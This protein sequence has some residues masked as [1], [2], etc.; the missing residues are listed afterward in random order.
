MKF[1][2]TSLGQKFIMALSGLGLVVFVILHLAGNLSLYGPTGDKFNAY[3]ALLHSFGWLTIAGEIG[4]GALIFTHAILAI[5]IKLGNKAA[6]PQG[7]AVDSTKGGPSKKSPLSTKMIFSGLLIMGFVIFHVKQFRFAPGMEAYTI[8][9]PGHDA[10][11]R[12]LHRLVVETFKD[13]MNVGIYVL[14]MLFLAA[15]IRH[16]FWSAFQSTG[17]AVSRFS[18]QIYCLALVLALLLAA[19]FL[20]I[21]VWIYFD[22]GAHI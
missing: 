10:P 7:Y 12:D 11:V 15:H 19:G 2:K 17:Y 6:R 18:K 1:L 22:L 14:V 21:P 4:L 9:L 8:Q 20:M 16:G 13:P 5:K 3:A